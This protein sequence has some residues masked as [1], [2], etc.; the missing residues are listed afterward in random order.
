MADEIWLDV[1]PSMRNLAPELIKG[2]S[3]AAKDAGSKAGKDY[4]GAFSDGADGAS[5]A[6]V[7]ELETAQKRATGL[8]AKL[9]GDVS[10]ARQAQQKSAAAALDAETKLTTAVE[11]YGA[12]SSQA[13]AATLRLEAARGKAADDTARFKNAENGLREAQKSLTVTTEQ[14]ETAQKNVG[15]EVAEQPK[16]WGKFGAALAAA[17]QKAEDFSGSVGGMITNLAG[18]V[19][20]AALLTE[21]FGT[22]L[23]G[24][25]AVDR[26]SAALGATPAQAEAYGAAAGALYSNGFGENMD[27][28]STAVDAVVSSMAGMR[29]A[30]AKD[31]E[32]ITGHAMNLA[33]AFDVDVAEAATAAGSLMKNGLA[34]DAT[35]AFDLITGAMQQI[36]QSL[37]GEVLPVMDEYGKHF[38]ALGIDG[39]TAMGMIVAASADGAIGMD[40]MGDALKEFTIR[41]TDMSKGTSGVY[42]TLG[43]DMEDMTN[44]LLAGGETAEGAMAQIVHGLQ[45]IKDPGEQAA[46]S[47]ALFGTPLE[48][49]GTDQIPNFLG[50][51]DPMGDAFASLDGK[52]AEMGKTLND[53][54][55]VSLETVKR[56]FMGM[57]TEGI[58]PALGPLKA[59]AD[60]ATNTPGVLEAVGIALGVVAVAWGYVTLAASPWLAIALGIGV[61]IA[62][63]ILVIQ[64]WGAIM[65]WLGDKVLKPFLNWIAPAWNAVMTGME[66]A[67]QNILK[68]VWDGIAAAANWLYKTILQPVFKWIGEAWTNWTNNAKWAW[69][70]ILKPVWDAVAAGGQWLW[71]TI[72]KPVFSGLKAGWDAA[73][74]G[75]KW[76]W[77]NIL[78]PVWDAVAA[79]GKWLWEKALKPAF[80]WVKSGWDGLTKNFGIIWDKYGEPVFSAISSL[81]KGDFPNAFKKGKEAVKN[82]WDSVAN[83]VRKPINFVIGTVYNDGLKAMFNGIASKLGLKWRLPD[84][85][86]LPAFAK[87]GLAKPGWALV[88][89][90]GPELVNFSSPGRVYTAS[91]TQ[92]ML[93]GREQ[94]PEGALQTLAGSS[95]AEAKL[96]AGGFWG[97]VWGNVTSAVGK[98]KDWVVG[99]IAEGVRALTT[100]LKSTISNFLP[101][102]GINELIRGGAHKLIDDMVGWAV[103]KDDAAEKA[104]AAEFGGAVYDGPLGRFH[105]PSK[106]PFTSMYGP[107]WGG[108]HTGVD[109]AG[110]GPTYAALPGVVQRVGWNAVAG[111]TGIGI[112]LNHGPGLWTYYGHNPVGG[113]RVKVGDQVKGGQHIGYQ[114]ATGNVTGTHVHFEV[115][116]G[117]VNG[118][119]N[120][121]KYLHDTGGVHEPGTWSYNGLKQPEYVFTEPQWATL[122]ALAARGA[123]AS[124]IPGDITVVI[125]VEDLEGI[126]T[127]EEFIAMARRRA[128]Q[129]KGSN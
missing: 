42:T 123:A 55:A 91:E 26:I 83:I 57:L 30:S 60:W 79:G 49:L 11:K 106:G 24:E 6:A 76:A 43:L 8:V 82:I 87:G 101:G 94:A 73:L 85:A 80:G 72:L 92:D 111:K 100:P 109:I 4:A 127:V 67:W 105:R 62:G 119:Q 77:N 97:D 23:E 38:A 120:P 71:N 64:N 81:L 1:L 113:P 51:V 116:K 37:R 32:A 22:A 53:N 102:A 45:N 50:M 121:M 110:G 63:L 124:E 66:W 107:R 128:R 54:T 12:G 33:G 68:P 10:K 70:N 69:Q 16:K 7:Q 89:E 44:K 90:E 34:K 112:Y 46:A 59:V 39:E 47:L 36:P 99:K 20:G 104:Q 3:K 5:D 78:K 114:G 56:S 14:L 18:A 28:V 2:A 61:A 41:A 93:G 108:F 29:D 13:E 74:N 126:K 35:G 27:D 117:R 88:G 84:V 129:K 40:K 52:A 103:N 21:A 96:P 15:Q 17:R 25:T 95:P 122:D 19:G 65:G 98:A 115:H 58:T 125:R 75:V 31:I 118:T 86:G 9:S 48:D